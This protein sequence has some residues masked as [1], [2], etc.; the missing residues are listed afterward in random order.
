MQWFKKIKAGDI[1]CPH[2]DWNRT[3]RSG[4]QL[5]DKVEV[6]NARE[7]TSQSGVL[8]LVRTKGGLLR[9]LD[10]GWFLNPDDK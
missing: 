10:A 9:T 1:L 7:A 4:N 5:P 2:P 8:F 3:E 6:I